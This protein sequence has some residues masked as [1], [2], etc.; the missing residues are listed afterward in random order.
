MKRLIIR[1]NF[2]TTISSVHIKKKKHNQMGAAQSGQK[3]DGVGLRFTVPSATRL[4]LDMATIQ[5][6]RQS[7]NTNHIPKNRLQ[8][9]VLFVLDYSTRKLPNRVFLNSVL[10]T[11]LSRQLHTH[12]ID[13]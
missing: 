3:T 10:L 4:S 2:I 9:N 13:T 5:R 1:Q 6:H 8:V 12:P 7:A 11:S